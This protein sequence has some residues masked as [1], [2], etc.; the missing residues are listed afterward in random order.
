MELYASLTRMLSCSLPPKSGWYL[1]WARRYAFLIS[2]SD[3]V[4][5]TSSDWYASMR[6][7]A[8]RRRVDGPSSREVVPKLTPASPGRKRRTG[9]WNRHVGAGT[10]RS[11]AES[12]GMASSGPG[13]LVE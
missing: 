12:E 11:A 8:R 10:P 13:A 5:L 4:G 7:P 1:R 9:A 3:A 2:S 6:H